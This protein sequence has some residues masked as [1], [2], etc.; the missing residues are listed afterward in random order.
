MALPVHLRKLFVF[1]QSTAKRIISDRLCLLHYRSESKYWIKI[2]SIIILMMLQVSVGSQQQILTR[3]QASRRS[4]FLERLLAC[5]KRQN[6][7]TRHSWLFTLTNEAL[8]RKTQNPFCQY[9]YLIMF[10]TNSLGNQWWRLSIW[11][12]RANGSWRDLWLSSRTSWS[13]RFEG[14]SA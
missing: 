6:K 13:N 5:H 2:R 3:C 7:A 9:L 14:K 4:S 11:L 12:A 1:V 10:M 8:K